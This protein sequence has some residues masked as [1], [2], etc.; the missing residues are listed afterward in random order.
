MFPNFNWPFR[1]SWYWKNNGYFLILIFLLMT[2]FYLFKATFRSRTL[3]TIFQCYWSPINIALLR[4]GFFISTIFWFHRSRSKL[5]QI[6]P[7]N[8]IG[9]WWVPGCMISFNYRDLGRS[10]FAIWPNPTKAIWQLEQ[11]PPWFE[12]QDPLL[13][14]GHITKVWAYWNYN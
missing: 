10:S 4:T 14:G 6:Y 2:T 7:K 3:Y 8:W 1:L 9:P 12:E 13:F 5:I 11:E